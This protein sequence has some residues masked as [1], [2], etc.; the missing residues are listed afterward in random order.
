[1]YAGAKI[2]MRH[3]K[4]EQF[5]KIILAGAFG[6][7]I[8]KESAAR[9]GLFPDLAQEKISVVGNAAGDGA[10]MALL[11]LDKRADAEKV[12]RHVEFVELAAEPDFVKLFSQAM[13]FPHM[14][15]SFPSLHQLPS[16]MSIMS[17]VNSLSHNITKDIV[18]R[19]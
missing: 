5:D 19:F 17:S 14:K 6:S 10:R 18:A 11:N 15:D 12:A 9:I 3:L 8:D 4:V 16:S 2:I 1:M 13:W 7:Y